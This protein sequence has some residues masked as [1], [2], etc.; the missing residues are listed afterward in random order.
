MII[1]KIPKT[2]EEFKAYYELRYAVL[3][4]PWGQPRD[5]EK[6]DYEPISQH[7]MAVD[8]QTGKVVGVVKL[9]EKS[10][11]VGWFSHLAVDQQFQR[12]GIGLKLLET[13]ESAAKQNG[14][15]VLGCMAR[16]NTTAYFEKRG[17]TIVGLPSH[18]FGTTQVVWMEKKI[19]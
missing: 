12:K 2:R 7:F 13:V 19:A 1:I 14:Y 5:T 6:D 15:T 8:E 16:L 10:A 17:F 3:R 4:K 11:G 18:Y 9:F